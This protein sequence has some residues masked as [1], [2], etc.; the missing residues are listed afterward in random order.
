[1]RATSA[2]RIPP[3]WFGADRPM[4]VH[5]DSLR[6]GHKSRMHLG[7]NRA[8]MRAGGAVVRHSRACG[9]RSAAYSTIASESQT[10]TSPSTSAGTLPDRVKPEN[11]LLFGIRGVERDQDFLEGDVAGFQPTHGRIGP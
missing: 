8:R 2:A 5:A 10:V 11:T 7:G 9:N 4:Q 3:Q 6:S 1:M